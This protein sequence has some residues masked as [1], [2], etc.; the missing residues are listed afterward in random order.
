[1]SLGKINQTADE[2]LRRRGIEN[3]EVRHLI[4]L[5]SI[6]FLGGL[7]LYACFG[8]LAHFGAYALGG[9]LSMGNF[10]LLAKIVP[11]VIGGQKGGTF[12]LLFGFYL[13]LLGT[14]LILFLAVAWLRM[15]IVSLLLGLSTVFLNIVIWLG[16]FILTHKHKEA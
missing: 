10:Y 16:K 7:I 14:G 12:V 8:S 4:V 9:C 13:R 11:Q 2:V 5:H 3:P 1:M 6:I 15:P